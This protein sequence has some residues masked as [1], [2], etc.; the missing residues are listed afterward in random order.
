MR[1]T[2][3][4]LASFATLLAATFSA[5]AQAAN[6]RYCLQGRSWGYP[7]NCQFVSY[8]QCLAAA[9]GTSSYCGIN[10]HYAFAQRYSY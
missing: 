5:P 6:D 3:L 2:V 9:S 7:G 8:Q 4:T 1:R 10:P